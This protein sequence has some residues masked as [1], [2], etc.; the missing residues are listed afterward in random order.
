MTRRRL[1][2]RQEDLSAQRSP[3]TRNSPDHP[4]NTTGDQMNA[5]V[6]DRFTEVFTKQTSIGLW[7]AGRRDRIFAST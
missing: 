7:P 2:R 1:P 5:G 4:G 6:I 3:T